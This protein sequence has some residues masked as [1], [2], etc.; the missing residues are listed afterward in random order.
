M[1]Q[2]QRGVFL[3]DTPLTTASTVDFRYY[4][5]PPFEF[6]EQLHERL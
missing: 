1:R 5:P 3:M 4:P 2:E 6:W